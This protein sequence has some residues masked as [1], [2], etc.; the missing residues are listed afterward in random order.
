MRKQERGI[1]MIGWVVLLIPIAIVGYAGIRLTP[2]YLNY[3]K[4]SKALNTLAEQHKGEDQ[5]NPVALRISLEKSFDVDSIDYPS[6]KDV[7]FHREGTQWVA[8]VKYE[9]TVP[10]FAD[11]SLLVKFDKR[12][13][14]H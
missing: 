11:L 5:L 1:T 8:Q 4:V 12:V 2:I 14:F 7:D 13:E 6:V 3:M 9:D 10:L